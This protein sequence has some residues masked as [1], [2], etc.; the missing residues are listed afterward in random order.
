MY[1]LYM[2]ECFAC[3]YVCAVH[4]CLVPA[5]DRRNVVSLETETIDSFKPP[6]RCWEPTLSS[7]GGATALNCCVP[8]PPLQTLNILEQLRLIAKFPTCFSL[9]Q[10]QPSPLS[11]PLRDWLQVTVNGLLP[12]HHCHREP[13]ACTI[14]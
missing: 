5:E 14:P 10:D 7:A 13:V 3:T 8:T 6:C 12:P 4:E 1:L 9:S 11:T 2:Y